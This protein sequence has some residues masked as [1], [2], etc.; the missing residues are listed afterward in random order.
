MPGLDPQVA[1]HQLNID[2][3]VNPLRLLMTIPSTLNS[4]FIEWSI[5]LQQYNMEFLPQKAI[6]GQVIANIVA[7]NQ[8]SKD[9]RMYDGLLDE[10]AEAFTMQMAINNQSGNSIL[11]VQHG[12][13]Q[14]V[15]RLPEWGLCLFPPKNMFSYAHSHYQNHALTMKQSTMLS[16]ST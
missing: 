11:T 14:V 12:L 9:V 2:P 13:S 8:P 15:I 16:F 6:I 10:V 5:V 4:C 3:K 1:M 7:V